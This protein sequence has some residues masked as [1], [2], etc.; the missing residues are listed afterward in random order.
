[1]EVVL[2]RHGQSGN[3][4]IWEQ[5]GGIAGR[6]PD[7]PLTDL[8]LAQADALARWFARDAS[9]P[10]VTELHTSLM[11]RAVQTAAPLAETLDLPL[12]GHPEIFEV[13]GPYEEDE[14]TGARSWHPGTPM[15]ALRALT[16]RL[17][18][19]P[20]DGGEVW[21]PGP[22]EENAVAAERGRRVVES[23]IQPGAT[24][25]PRV[26]ALVTHGFFTQFLIR[27]LLGIGDMTGWIQIDNT[28]ISRF[29]IGRHGV[30]ATAL[31]GVSHLRPDQISS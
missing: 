3:N 27:A 28:A 24:E 21:W 4:L 10:R 8:G 30:V 26:I 22:F 17:Q 14:E 6:D 12:L 29:E 7:S 11:H 31:N 2:I 16:S 19:D 15:S 18:H 25:D 1:M 5:T 9:A 20:V 23:L 13:G